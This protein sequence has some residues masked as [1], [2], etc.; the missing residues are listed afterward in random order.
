MPDFLCD[1]I[2]KGI[3]DP[4]INGERLSRFISSILGKEVKVIHSLG[5]EGFHH[6]T[7]SKGIILDIVVQFEDGSIGNVE[8][9]R[10]GV[11]FPSKRAA[12]YSANIVTRQFAT[13]HGEMKSELDYDI[14]KPVY[15]IVI[16]EKSLKVFHESRDYIHHFK[17]RSD[18]GLELELVQYYDYICLDMFKKKNPRVA[19]ELESWLK[20]FTIE[21]VEEMQMFLAENPGFQSVYDYAIMMTKDR[22]GLLSMLSEYFENEDIVASLNKTNESMVKRLEQENIQLKDEIIGLQDSNIEKDRVIDKKDAE[23]Q[24]LKEL[25]E[26]K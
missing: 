24:R 5:N 6:S 15:T 26:K 2:F 1:T 10:M 17:Q 3:F 9:Q 20:F 25:L 23:I 16:M 14:V 11:A 7:Y 8:I 22:E 21:K 13:I 19:S 12:V 18:T 4:E